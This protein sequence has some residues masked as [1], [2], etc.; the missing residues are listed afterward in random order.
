MTRLIEYSKSVEGF[1][2]EIQDPMRKIQ[3]RDKVIWTA[4]TLFIYLV[5]CQIPLYG[6]KVTGSDPLYWM[7]VILASNRGTLMEL[8]TSPII[9]SSMIVQLLVNSKII[10][11]NMQDKDDKRMMENTQKCKYITLMLSII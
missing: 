8:G 10:S 11:C 2:P 4:V 9:T 7:R 5:C 6:V 3:F 1:I